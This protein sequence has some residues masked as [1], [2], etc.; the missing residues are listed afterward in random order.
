MAKLFKIIVELYELVIT[1]RKNDRYGRVVSMGSLKPDD[2][3]ALA[4][5]RRTD[6]S[7]ELIKASYNLL[8]AIALEEVC[9]GKN[10]EFGLSHYSLVSE[11][12]FIGDHS[13]WNPEVNKLMISSASTLETRKALENIEVE[14]RGMAQSGLCVNKLTDVASGKVNERL[15]PGGAVN[16]AGVKIRI[17]G[18]SPDNG[19]FLTEINSGTITQIPANSIPIN[20]PSKITFVIPADLP[21]GDYHL[22]ITTQYSNAKQTL[23]EPRTFVFEYV[24]TCG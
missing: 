14:V 7:P 5:S 1:T 18:D 12:V 19:I 21:A 3:I 16:L 11:G 4:V 20:D 10:V 24:L 15:T 8:K 17:A 2:L 23:L 13:H 22:S 9:N 6:L